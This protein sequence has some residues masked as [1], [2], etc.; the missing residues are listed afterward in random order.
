MGGPLPRS[1]IRCG[2]SWARE[3][4]ILR[5]GGTRWRPAGSPPPHS[6]DLDG[7]RHRYDRSQSPSPLQPVIRKHPLLDLPH[8]LLGELAAHAEPVVVYLRAVAVVEWDALFL[9]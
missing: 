2:S 8:R 1:A 5:A 3:G 9:A 7:D 6:P 4:G